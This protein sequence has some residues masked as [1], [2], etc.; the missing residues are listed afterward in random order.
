M[1]KNIRHIYVINYEINIAVPDNCTVYLINT[2]VIELS[3]TRNLQHR[4][5][6]L[7]SYLQGLLAAIRLAWL[8]PWLGPLVARFTRHF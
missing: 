8:T 1:P 3:Y 2:Y 6:R 7:F 4:L 5:R